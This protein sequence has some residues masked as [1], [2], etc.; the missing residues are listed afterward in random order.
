LPFVFGYAGNL[1]GGIAS[2]VLT[3]K[4]DKENFPGI[5]HLLNWFLIISTFWI[6]IFVLTMMSPFMRGFD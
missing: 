4:T 1:F 3:I 6:L 5:G 2:L